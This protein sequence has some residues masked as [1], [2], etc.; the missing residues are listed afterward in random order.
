M[1]GVVQ[2]SAV[3]PDWITGPKYQPR[4]LLYAAD[5]RTKAAGAWYR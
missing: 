4:H 1:A 2:G 5:H 3:V